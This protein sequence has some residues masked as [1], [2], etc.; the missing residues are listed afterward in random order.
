VT[1]ARN[2]VVPTVGIPSEGRSVLGKSVGLIVIGRNVR[3]SS[4]IWM[5]FGIGTSRQSP[6]ESSRKT[7]ALPLPIQIIA[8]SGASVDCNVAQGATSR[9]TVSAESSNASRINSAVTR[10]PLPSGPTATRC[11]CKSR[12]PRMLVS[13]RAMTSSTS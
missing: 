3:C 11:P 9:V 13:D 2:P 10:N 4:D 6:C 5:P 8:A 12:M 1:A 7:I